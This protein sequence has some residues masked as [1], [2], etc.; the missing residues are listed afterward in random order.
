M[1]NWK[2][3]RLYTNHKLYA[4]QYMLLHFPYVRPPRKRKVRGPWRPTRPSFNGAPQPTTITVSTV[5]IIQ[6][7][8]GHLLQEE[9]S[10]WGP[11]SPGTNRRVKTPSCCYRHPPPTPTQSTEAALIRI[12][13]STRRQSALQ[14]SRGSARYINWRNSGTSIPL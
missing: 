8:R 7:T 9:W 13:N 6:T 1:E 11:Y 3:S 10:K 12:I 14:I 4:T 5:N 2:H